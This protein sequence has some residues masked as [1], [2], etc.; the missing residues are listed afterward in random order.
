[1]ISR[2]VYYIVV[3]LLFITGISLMIYEHVTFDVPWFPSSKNIAW[4]IEAKI[5][6]NASYDENKP[7]KVS[8]AVPDSQPG[9]RIVSE[10]TA[11]PNYGLFFND[12]AGHTRAEWSNRAVTGHQILYYR[13]GILADNSVKN[14][15]VTVPRVGKVVL[16]EPYLTA[17]NQIGN[18]AW[19]R[20]SDPLSFTQAI[21]QEIKTQDQGGK[22]GGRPP[23]SASRALPGDFRSG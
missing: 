19:S 8:L 15:M 16:E 14:N 11:S 10:N 6:F 3:A 20:S 13:L 18:A 4:D 21:F 2:G 23:E 7:V 5:S 9:F 12:R 17:I 1:M 22:A